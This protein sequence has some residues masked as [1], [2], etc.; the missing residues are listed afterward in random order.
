MNMKKRSLIAMLVVFFIAS[1]ASIT[2]GQNTNVIPDG[3]KSFKDSVSYMI[4]LDIAQNLKRGKIEIVDQWLLQGLRDALDGKDS[5]V[6]QQVKDG[7][8]QRW[9]AE[10]QKK[11]AEE[12]A[13]KSAI[14]KAEGKAFLEKNKKEKGV[15]ELPSGLQYK[16]VTEGKGAHPKA[17]DK[18]KVHYHGTLV[19]GTV[20][21]SSVQRGE[22]VT[23]PLNQVIK[24]WTEGVQLMTPGSKYVFYIP[25]DLAYGDREVSVIPAGSTLI[26]EV[27]LLDILPADAK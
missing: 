5:L 21:D 23:F 3:V 9:Q 27:E 17:T 11:Q 14:A 2:K 19:N 6:P 25:S 20:F 7:V 12:T 15:K 13:K 10:Q 16:V 22:P 1:N 18:V 8:I 4:G 24:G 26:F